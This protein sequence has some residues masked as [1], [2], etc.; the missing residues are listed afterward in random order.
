[1]VDKIISRIK[2]NKSGEQA[3]SDTGTS[4]VD[5]M[6]TDNYISGYNRVQ[7]TTHATPNRVA[8]AIETKK[9]TLGSLSAS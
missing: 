9:V 5:V 1:M 6:R 8:G 2:I 7:T 4:Y 3:L